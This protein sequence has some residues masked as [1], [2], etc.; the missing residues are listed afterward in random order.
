MT[1]ESW[2]GLGPEWDR[3]FLNGP[4]NRGKQA[5]ILAT[6][7]EFAHQWVNTMTA[8]VAQNLD[9]GEFVNARM[10]A[11][12]DWDRARKREQKAIHYR[13]NP[14]RRSRRLIER[15]TRQALSG[16][17]TEQIA[18]LRANLEA[19]R[20]E[21]AA[22]QGQETSEPRTTRP[23]PAQRAP[24]AATRSAAT[25]AGPA[26]H[27]GLADL[28]EGIRSDYQALA[29]DLDLVTTPDDT[30]RTTW[31]ELNPGMSGEL[32]ESVLADINGT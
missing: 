11:L 30:L 22:R 29:P 21:Y 1:R 9:D 13:F 2:A 31:A 14:L 32:I 5:A 18:E 26:L 27:P 15:D 20:A 23:R 7:I 6:D 8:L 24:R 3:D 17:T 25:P 16:P 28:D 19:V 4:R 10:A 12:K